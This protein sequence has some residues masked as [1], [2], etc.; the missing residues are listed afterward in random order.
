MRIAFRSVRR[1][2]RKIPSGRPRHR[3]EDNIKLD[4][5]E[6]GCET[7]DWIH[8]AQDRVHRWAQ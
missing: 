2:E 3:R 6:V 1:P 8:P 7:V 5:K 4:F